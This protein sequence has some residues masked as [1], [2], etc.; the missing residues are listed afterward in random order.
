MDKKIINKEAKNLR[1]FIFFVMNFT[2][3]LL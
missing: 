2:G 1:L 3:G